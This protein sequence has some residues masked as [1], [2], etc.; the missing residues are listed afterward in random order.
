MVLKSVD[1]VLTRKTTTNKPKNN[2]Q[3]TM[4]KGKT[5]AKCKLQHGL[6]LCCCKYNEK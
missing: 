3:T 4:E 2:Q 1:M 5:H 6:Q